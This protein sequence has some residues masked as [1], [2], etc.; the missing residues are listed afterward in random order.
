M[1]QIGQN[2][3]RR[4]CKDSGFAGK[5]CEGG[6][7]KFKDSRDLLKD[8]PSFKV[9]K[10]LRNRGLVSLQFMKNFKGRLGA[11]KAVINSKPEREID[12]EEYWLG[13]LLR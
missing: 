13:K 4:P 10:K 9:V 12:D 8:S 11:I 5:D 2:K 3:Q 1:H 7:Y 6:L